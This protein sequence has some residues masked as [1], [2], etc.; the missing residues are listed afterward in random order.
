MTIDIIGELKDL[1]GDDR[2]HQDPDLLAKRA[3]DTW[4]LKLVQKAVGTTMEQPLCVVQPKS[5]NEVATLLQFLNERA[6]AA[7]PY[8]GFRGQ[9][10]CPA[11]S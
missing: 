7:V 3:T 9:W 4:P 2:V 1:L 6:V 10:G 8:G 5:T 11:K